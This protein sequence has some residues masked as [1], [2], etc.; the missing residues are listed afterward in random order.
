MTSSCERS[1]LASRLSLTRNSFSSADSFD[2]DVGG[3]SSSSLN[4]SSFSCVGSSSASSLNVSS[5][6][7]VGSSS[8]SS[9]NVS[10]FSVEGSSSAL[11]STYVNKQ[12]QLYAKCKHAFALLTSTCYTFE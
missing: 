3:S 4:V 9:L 2:V 11:S 8:V 10:S 6:S 12:I 7:F 1:D 5:F